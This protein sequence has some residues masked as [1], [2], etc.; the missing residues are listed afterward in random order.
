MVN[1]TEC[2]T[3]PDRYWHQ[4][5]TNESN[6]LSLPPVHFKRACLLPY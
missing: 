2:G 5:T 3:S 6:T 1:R 4:Q